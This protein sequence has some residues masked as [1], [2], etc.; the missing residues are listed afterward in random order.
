MVTVHLVEEVIGSI[1]IETEASS[2][3]TLSWFLVADKRCSW[4]EF[5]SFSKDTSNSSLS[6]S[7]PDLINLIVSVEDTG[8]GIPQEDQSRIFTPFVQVG[9]SIS[10]RQGGIG[11]GLSI[12][13]CLVNLMNGEI[14]FMSIPKIGSTFT[15]TIVFTNDLKSQK[16]DQSSKM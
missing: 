16:L 4:A 13:K 2:R 8:K 10:R 7:S 12:S 1:D 3:N 9:P 15:F 6:Q 11:I 14:G 5:R